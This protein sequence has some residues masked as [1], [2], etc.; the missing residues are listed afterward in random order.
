MS[1]RTR[2]EKQI[3]EAFKGISLEA[4]I[5]SRSFAMIT[6]THR[7]KYGA[8]AIEK[9]IVNGNK[10]NQGESFWWTYYPPKS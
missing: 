10:W 7:Y 4:E 6:T 2:P 5:K 3:R 9:Q 1:K 8:N